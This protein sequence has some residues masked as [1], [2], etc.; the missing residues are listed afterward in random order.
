MKDF[1]EAVACG[2]YARNI[3]HRRSTPAQPGRWSEPVVPLAP[4]LVEALA[5]RGIDRLFEHQAQ[6]L[7]ALARGDHV[8]VVTPTASG[9]SLI[10]QIPAL[11]AAR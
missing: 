9:K 10:Y 6:A 7:D 1:L 8:M 3:V 4:N 11:Q 5:A 2:R